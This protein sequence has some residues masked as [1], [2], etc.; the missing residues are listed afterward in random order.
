MAK[1]SRFSIKWGIRADDLAE[2]EGVTPDAIHMRVY[3]WHTPWR[4]RARPT[5]WE[6]AYGQSLT[7][8]CDHYDLSPWNITKRT[9]QGI[10]LD[11][12]SQSTYDWRAS[13]TVNMKKISKPF[14]LH[15][16]HQGYELARKGSLTDSDIDV[17][18]Q[19]EN[20]Y[21]QENQDATQNL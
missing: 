11:Q 19:M 7:E 5:K 17:I 21:N 3:L 20:A 15:P 14:W 13:K 16:E 1:H 18:H 6:I 12:P 2:Q 8:L 4:R 10:P 9:S